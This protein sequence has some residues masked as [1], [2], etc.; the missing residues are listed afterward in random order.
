[1][2]TDF[3]S[4]TAPERPKARAAMLSRMFELST[5]DCCLQ[6]IRQ[7]WAGADQKIIM[8]LRGVMVEGDVDET[9]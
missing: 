6:C 8:E 5:N 2:N 1:M 9:V 3:S 4:F 7:N